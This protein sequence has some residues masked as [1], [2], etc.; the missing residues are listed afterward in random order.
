M[1]SNMKTLVEI[2]SF[3]PPVSSW[4]LR[5]EFVARSWK[6]QGHKCL[7]M[8]IGSFRSLGNPKCVNIKGPFDYVIRVLDSV[9][10]GY[11]IHTHT[12]AKGVKGTLLSLCAHLIS[13]CF[14]RRCVLTFHAGIHQQYFPRTGRFFLDTLMS[15]TFR[16][17]RYIICNSEAVKERIVNDYGIPERRVFPIPAFC[18]AYM[19]TNIGSL[20]PEIRE[21]AE[22]HHPLILSYVFFFHSEF[23]VDEM[24]HAVKRL[25]NQ[26]PDLGLIITGSKRYVEDYIKMIN[27][28]NLK[29]H[30]LLTGG[31]PREEFLGALQRSSLYLRTPMGDGVAA[32][33]LESLSFGIPVVASDNGTRPGGCILYQAGNLE[34]MVEKIRYVLEN[35]EK[36]V[37]QIVKPD[38]RDTIKDEIDL[39]LSVAK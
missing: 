20:S 28:M 8:N 31:L 33:V 24:I 19:Q 21:F 9:L 36:A 15:L 27:E 26:Y 7:L 12:N 34:D 3:P 25:R 37:S 22:Q 1:N 13:L 23:A 39:L 17:P 11:V 10:K 4:S 32:T 30:I 16:T 5:I 29:E 6:E 35:R 18:E 14:G 2:A 38:R